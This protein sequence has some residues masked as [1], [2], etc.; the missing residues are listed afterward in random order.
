M[1]FISQIVAENP[2]QFGGQGRNQ[3]T[4]DISKLKLFQVF[5]EIDNDLSGFANVFGSLTVSSVRAQ[6]VLD[7]Q[8][9]EF[10]RGTYTIESRAVDCQLR[11]WKQGHRGISINTDS[12]HKVTFAL[13]PTPS[14]WIDIAIYFDMAPETAT[15]NVEPRLEECTVLCLTFK[16]SADN[17]ERWDAY[18]HQAA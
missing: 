2:D 15:A 11:I 7:V 17:A 6:N 12:I 5:R 13:S 9:F 10:D 18:I 3:G 1:S 8:L 16:P 4:V 14:S